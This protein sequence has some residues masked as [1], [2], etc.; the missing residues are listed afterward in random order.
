MQKTMFD[1]GHIPQE[2]EGEAMDLREEPTIPNHTL[3][4]CPYTQVYKEYK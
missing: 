2:S 1:T 4:I 3:N